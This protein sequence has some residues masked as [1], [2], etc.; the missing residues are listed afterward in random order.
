MPSLCHL[1]PEEPSGE[2][3]LHLSCLWL[4]NMARV[5]AIADKL[6]IEFALIH[7]ERKRRGA[8]GELLVDGEEYMEVLVGNIED[9][10]AIL[11]DD[12][13]DTGN[14]LSLAAHTL[15]LKGAKAVY[16]LISHGGL[17]FMSFPDIF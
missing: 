4:M 16:A 10:V 13:I 9:K 1:T 8:N 6:G 14:T 17:Y 11:V 5:T 12:M 3:V 15:A 7:R 2:Y